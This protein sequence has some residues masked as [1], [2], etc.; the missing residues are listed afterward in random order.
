MEGDEKG[1]CSRLVECVRRRFRNLRLLLGETS[2]ASRHGADQQQTGRAQSTKIINEVNEIPHTGQFDLSTLRVLHSRLKATKSELTV[3]NAEVEAVMTDE[4]AIEDYDSPPAATDGN[5]PAAFSTSTAR[6]RRELGAKLPKLEL[7]C[8]DG[9]ITKWQPFWDM[10]LHSVHENPRLSDT[11]SF[12]YLVSLVDGA[13][14]KPSR[15]S[16]LR[17]QVTTTTLES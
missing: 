16:V 14:S 3:L 4:Q 15:E 2:A 7:V 12:H 1:V 13:A 9:T 11:D 5:Q 10:F 8:F 17:N 6:S